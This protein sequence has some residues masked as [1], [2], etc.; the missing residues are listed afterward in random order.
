MTNEKDNF[1]LKYGSSIHI[2]KIISRND[3]YLNGKIAKEIPE[4]HDVLINHS[5]PYVRVAV[6]SN[7]NKNHLDKLSNDKNYF[8]RQE[9]KNRNNN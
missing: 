1:L 8:V 9:I 6:A 3:R 5:D 7:C 4:K 2:D